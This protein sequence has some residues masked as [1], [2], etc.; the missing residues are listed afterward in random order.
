MSSGS[1]A[2]FQNSPGLNFNKILQAA[3]TPAD[4]KSAKK[5]DDLTVFFALLGSAHIEV[6]RKTFVK[7]TT[8]IVISKIFYGQIFCEQ[9]TKLQKRL[10]T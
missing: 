10:T 8:S 3:F 4:P 9:I 5:T 7:L 1:L 6:A 2:D